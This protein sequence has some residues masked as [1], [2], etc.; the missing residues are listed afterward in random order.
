MSETHLITA[1]SVE[2]AIE[3]ANRTYADEK[4]EVSY[5]IVEMPKKGFLGIG[6][7]DAKIRVTVNKVEDVDLA[8]LVSDIRSLK[9]QTDGY[10]ASSPKPQKNSGQGGGQNGGQNGAKQ[11]EQRQNGG[12]GGGQNGGQSRQAREPREPRQNAQNN[13]PSGQPPRQPKESRQN[14]QNN[15]GERR[16]TNQNQNQNQRQTNPRPETVKSEVRTA[17]AKAGV[18]RSDGGKTETPKPE[19]RQQDGRRE[20]K[21]EQRPAGKPEIKPDKLDRPAAANRS[22]VTM[23]KGETGAEVKPKTGPETMAEADK[24]MTLE[25]FP[26]EKV[27]DLP[28]VM[29][30]EHTEVIVSSPVSLYDIPVHDGRQEHPLSHTLEEKSAAKPSAEPAREAEESD[31]AE[32]IDPLFRYGG[33]EENTT[34]LDALTENIPEEDVLEENVPEEDVL[35]ENI[36]EEETETGPAGQ[37]TEIRN[38]VTEE[39]M[40]YALDFANTLL[41]NMEID[42][43]AEAG[44]CPEGEFYATTEEAT[45]YPKIEISGTG[46]GILIGHHGDTLDAIQYLCNLAAIRRSNRGTGEY[47]KIIVDVE[48]YRKK[49]E[50]TLRALA[51]RMAARAVRAK[52]N[53]FLEPMNAYERRIIHSELQNVENVATHSVG[54]DKNRKIIITYEGPDKQQNSRRRQKRPQGQ[55]GRYGQGQYHGSRTET[56][57]GQ[58]PSDGSPL[59]GSPSYGERRGKTRY[60]G[61]NGSEQPRPKKPQKMPIENLP[62]FLAANGAEPDEFLSME[63]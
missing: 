25:L 45:V 6:A 59:Y 27:A 19:Q 51:R 42:A 18:T 15:G 24:P 7:K 26:G 13:A 53:M 49:R 48:N 35:E 41:A 23:P 12:Q 47:I 14:P 2:E 1:K 46:T 43:H 54:T 30:K 5:E 4:H 34:A 57:N 28:D 62:D 3:I 58:N 11:R 36:P 44:V 37:E 60:T 9:I 16:Q 10:A 21:A 8:S 63:D 55:Y 39:E 61:E 52:K 20:Q 22:T 40:A 50:E 33:E 38:A 56:D 31:T 32:E 17:A 29:P